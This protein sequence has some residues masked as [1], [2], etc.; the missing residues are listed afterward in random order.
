MERIT[1]EL[2]R[3]IA[4]VPTS[5]PRL[6]SLLLVGAGGKG[7]AGATA[8]AAWAA[9]R[10]SSK[11]HADYVRLITAID[12]LTG[13]GAAGDEARAAA[14]VD[15]FA[16]ARESKA[17]LLVLDDV[18]QLCGGTGPG[19]Y[20][21]V[22]IATLRALLRTPPSSQT[23]AK[24]GGN[25]RPGTTGKSMQVIAATSRSDAACVTLNQIFSETLVVP[26]L[27]KREDVAKLFTDCTISTL[28]ANKEKM[29]AMIL[30]K[31]GPVG[32]KTALRIAERSVASTGDF[33][34]STTELKED[35]QLQSLSTILDDLVGEEGSLTDLCNIA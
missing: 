35:F 3:F 29:A 34:S 22:M 12:L 9:A 33:Q 18:D 7:G 28:I 19:G 16:E 11:G 25:S 6:Q 30:D 21:S 15:K 27:S 23:I 17:S 10:A 13:E 8:L 26:L 24:A 20:S 1:R 4:P 5:S 14:L 31:L 32:C 2:E